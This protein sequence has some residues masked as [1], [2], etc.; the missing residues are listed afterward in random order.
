MTEKALFNDLMIAIDEEDIKYLIRNK[1]RYKP[2]LAALN[3]LEILESPQVSVFVGARNSGK[4]FYNIS[5]AQR[6]FNLE[7]F[8]KIIKEDFYFSICSNT[9]SPM[10]SWYD[11]EEKQNF[12]KEMLK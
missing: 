11:D 8:L 12:V 9:F 10:K 3:R 5:K 7:K 1:E 4:Q 2:I 6:T